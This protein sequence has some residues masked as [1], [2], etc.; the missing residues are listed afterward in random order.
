MRSFLVGLYS[1]FI[2]AALRAPLGIELMQVPAL[3]PG[4]AMA[5]RAAAFFVVAVGLVFGLRR[6]SESY[7]PVTILL[8][9]TLGYGLQWQLSAAPPELT[10]QGVFSV[11]LVVMMVASHRRGPNAKPSK[12]R[13]VAA[14]AVALAGW[15]LLERGAPESHATAVFAGLVAMVSIGAIGR[16]TV[17]GERSGSESPP[18]K[19]P[20]TGRLSGLALTGAGLAILMEGL[21][22]HLRL[23]GGGAAADDGVFAAVFLGLTAFGAISF[24]RLFA[25]DKNVTLGRGILGGTCAL[26]AWGSLQ[27]LE[28]FS[29]SRNLEVFV[30]RFGGDFSRHGMLDYDAVIA[31]PVLI[32]PAF[33]VGTIIAL[34]RR[35]LDLPALL[36]GGAAGTVMVPG[37]LAY[38]MAT[39]DDGVLQVVESTNSAAMALTGAAI[40]A[41]G[42]MLALL[43]AHEIPL[44]ARAVGAA[45]A[46]AGLLGALLPSR[47]PIVILDP[48]ALAEPRASWV[49]DGAEGQIT[50]E[51]DTT[52]HSI[53][54]LDR[55]RLTPGGSDFATDARRIAMATELLP[56][57]VREAG[58]RVLLIGQL[59]AE[60]ALALTDGG[61]S[62]IDRTGS[63]YGAMGLIEERLFD[64]LPAWFEGEVLS[65]AA[66]RARLDG[67]LYDLVIVPAIPGCA[68][69][70][71]NL[72]SPAET[73]VVLWFDG[74]G[75]VESQ[76]FGERV[77]V[78][79]PGLTELF[80]GIARGP[81]VEQHWIAGEKGSIAFPLIADPIEALDPREVL[82]TRMAKRPDQHRARLAGRLAA[83]ELTEGIAAGLAAHFE[84]QAQS[85][86][87]LTD[88][89]SVELDEVAMTRF[90][91]SA[92]GSTPN[93][94]EID[95]IESL[96]RLLTAQRKVEEIDRFLTGPAD[97]HAPW[98]ALEVPL[99]QASLE[100]LDPE[101]ALERLNRIHQIW[102]GTPATWAMQAEAQ[103]QTKDAAGAASS[104]ERALEL[105]PDSHEIERRLAIAW[106]WAG[107]PRGPA[108]L[109]ASLE[110]DPDDPELLSHRSGGPPLPPP[111][112]F[113][114]LQEH[115]H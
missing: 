59:S 63:W 74:A 110:D 89:E 31:A 43:S 45:I 30:R 51:L 50:V 92:A 4:A 35:P 97:R 77:L 65:P 79:A 58:S 91:E 14:A 39:G 28:N 19:R 53:A 6:V 22:R 106:M 57:T 100:F 75:G 27:V 12:A 69:T 2:L 24:G 55:R 40:A 112:G 8:G 61:A 98:V 82:L 62:R 68:P 83:A 114:R 15:F 87:F 80:V 66:A 54:T 60:R 102:S 18:P 5:Y 9:V 20:G 44:R 42:S 41:G 76:H 88:E 93:R 13:V 90:S 113:H 36:I 105:A 86:P 115:E 3:A 71:R 47:G 48:W 1:G 38:R 34:C 78:D 104:L 64:G 46:L 11:L 81:A 52:G 7:R 101:T 99:A 107:D 67:G 96:A 32:L 25:T 33:F 109:A 85:S 70:T 37:L 94:I 73:T 26:A 16:L 95:V 21:L 103:Q 108:A 56:Q 29:G 111:G 10:L 23:L 17:A 72:A 84:A 49:L